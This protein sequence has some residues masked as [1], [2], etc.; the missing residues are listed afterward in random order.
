VLT[1]RSVGGYMALK[2][3]GV[4]E[5]YHADRSLRGRGTYRYDPAQKRVFWLS[6]VNYEMGRG[7]T[8]TAEQGGKVH[9]ILWGPKAYAINGE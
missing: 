9:R 3:G 5:L 6:G 4:Y 2:E 8:F 7:G 1:S